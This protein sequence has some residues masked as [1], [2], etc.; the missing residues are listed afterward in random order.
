MN[1]TLTSML[2]NLSATYGDSPA[3]TLG[4]TTVT[5]RQLEDSADRVAGGLARAGVV[6]G[7][8][9]AILD[10]NSIAYFELMFGCAAAGAVL[11][12]VNYRLAAR[13][14]RTVVQD[15]APKILFVSPDLETLVLNLA[16]PAGVDAPVTD[17]AAQPG[18]PVIV[19]L[20][21]EFELWAGPPPAAGNPADDRPRAH[22]PREDDVVLQMYSS[23]TTGLPKGAMLTH[24][25]LSFTPMMGRAFY[26]MTE[27]SVNLL[28][29][30]LF[31]IGGAGYGMTTFGQGGHTVLVRD[32]V[33]RN[34]LA[35]IARHRV[36]NMFLVPA[37]IDML[38][39]E[40]LTND[41]DLSSL[42][43]IAYG[44]APITT[45][46]LVA[47]A[48][49]LTCGFLGV[50]GMTEAAGTVAC[51]PQS[52]HD[53][54]GERSYL[55]GSV[56]V[57]LPWNEIKIIDPDTLQ[58]LEPGLVGELCVRSGQTM[59]GYWNQPEITA[60][61]IDADGWLHT[62]DAAYS[63]AAGY[64]FLKDRLKDMIISGGENIYPIEVENVLMEHPAVREVAVFGV[65]HLK[66]GETVRA[67]I[68][69]AAG[70]RLSAADVIEFCQSHLARY[71]CP[72]IVDFVDALPRNASGK[73]LK[74]V[75][76]EAPVVAGAPERVSA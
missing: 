46:Q 58:E 67:T 56:G 19:S 37:T 51:L 23:G 40:S 35:D 75:L 66:W 64:L 31:H 8:R 5:F 74:R 45:H 14:V 17:A 21:A 41:Y 65:P 73:I 72:T 53:L 76:R 10:K 48:S 7:D 36:T 52:D 60:A 70:Q 44:G 15:A 27:N 33:A 26:G 20:G 29:S 43:L 59:A 28:T 39:A 50:Y 11:V 4:A 49:V 2:R 62:G 71:K 12:A 3:L 6:P 47:A 68:V 61:T 69:I 38:L 32:F 30:P 25:N 13:E 42:A 57:P 63:D 55:L 9:V 24:R 22:E 34:V 54:T 18:R 1:N 16:A